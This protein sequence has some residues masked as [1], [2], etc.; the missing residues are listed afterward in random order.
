MLKRKTPLRRSRMKRSRPKPTDHPEHLAK[1]RKM[2]CCLDLD[3]YWNGHACRGKIVPHHPRDLAMGTGMS[4][5]S[6]DLDAFPLCT[7]HHD[8][9]HAGNGYFTFWSKAQKKEWQ[10]QWSAHYRRILTQ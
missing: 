8:E 6:S 3:T 7:K 5:K 2:G 9:F 10:R 4:L 1:L